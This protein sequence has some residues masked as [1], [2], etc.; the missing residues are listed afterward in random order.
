MET[1]QKESITIED[2]NQ[3]LNYLIEHLTE[4]KKYIHFKKLAII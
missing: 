4:P 1:L 2:V 3:K